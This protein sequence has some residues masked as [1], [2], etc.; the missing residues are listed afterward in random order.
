M[1]DNS[2]RELHVKYFERLTMFTVWSWLLQGFYFAGTTLTGI[3][4]L[5]SESQPSSIFLLNLFKVLFEIS[6]PVAF[7]VSLIVT[8]ILI[9]AAKRLTGSADNF[10]TPMGLLFHNANVVFMVFEIICNRIPL[11]IWHIQFMILYGM[12]YSVFSWFWNWRRGVYYYFFMDYER[13]GAVYWYVGLLS[14]FS[15]FYLLSCALSA[16]INSESSSFIP[17][18]VRTFWSCV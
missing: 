7:M 2:K 14:A 13:P 9:P 5:Q 3:W 4:Y 8:Y 11:E 15:L 6:F 1:R 12:L 16:A 18:M 17:Y 10:F